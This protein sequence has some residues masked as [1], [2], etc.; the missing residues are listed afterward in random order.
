MSMIPD[1]SLVHVAKGNGYTV[2]ILEKDNG[3]PLNY[4]R[5]GALVAKFDGVDVALDY[6]LKAMP[7]PKRAGSSSRTGRSTFNVFDSFEEAVDIFR[8]R[9]ESIVKFDEAELMVRDANENGN[10]VAYDVTGDY[11]DM[12]RHMEGVPET[13]GSLHNGTA[14]NRRVTL[15]INTN[16]HAMI[17]EES[18]N[19]RAERILRL[20]DSLESGGVR[21]E[22]IAIDSN[23][24]GHTEVLLKRHEETLLINDLAIVSNSDWKRRMIF[25]INEHSETWDGGYGSPKVFGDAVDAKDIQPENTNEI[26]IL[27]DGSMYGDSIDMSFNKLERLL[28]WEL[29]KPVPEV[30]TIKVSNHGV[31]FVDNGSRDASEIQRE[32]REVLENE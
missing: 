21:C 28:E 14:R 31:Y 26:A 1:E 12:G 23:E 25:R 11:I 15:V 13:F 3:S 2:G 27:V 8:N 6:I 19:H 4:L 18:I 17:G 10:E 22:I 20:V 9:P 5:K 30:S 32:G 7:T 29:S 24:C 16:Q